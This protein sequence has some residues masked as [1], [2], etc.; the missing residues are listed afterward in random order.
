MTLKLLGMTHNNGSKLMPSN[1][2][3]EPYFQMKLIKELNEDFRKDTP[4]DFRIGKIV[5]GNTLKR[6]MKLSASYSKVNEGTDYIEVLGFTGNDEKYGEGGVKYNSVQEI[7]RVTRGVSNLKQLEQHDNKN[8]Y[9]YHHYMVARDID[10]TSTVKG[11]TGAWYY[12]FEGRWSRGS[13]A[14]PL[15]FRELNFAPKKEE[16]VQNKRPY[17]SRRSVRSSKMSRRYAPFR[18][19]SRRNT[20]RG[21]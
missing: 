16:P 15:S 8:E 14:E 2:E 17:T 9:G 3:T 10:P 18:D 1:E 20:R 21:R 11:E 4:P 19:N 5:R 6:G 12:I 13:G 7:F